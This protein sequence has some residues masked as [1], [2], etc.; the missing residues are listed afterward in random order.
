MADEASI[1]ELYNGGRGMRFTVQDATAVPKGSLLELDAD[2]RVIVATN[3]ASPF[4]GIAAFEKVASDGTLEVTGWTDG[5]FDIL[6]DSGT[7]IRG[8]MMALSDATNTIETAVAGDLLLGNVVGKYLEAGT[9]AG[10]EAVR[11]NV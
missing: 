6:S 7:D 1:I 2:R 5:V 10:R 4:V 9:N 3:A 8:T 11:V